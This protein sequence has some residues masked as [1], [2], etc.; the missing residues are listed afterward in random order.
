MRAS[1]TYFCLEGDGAEERG[2]S[3]EIPPNLELDIVNRVSASVHSALVHNR[4]Y[5]S[6]L[7]SLHVVLDASCSI[8]PVLGVYGTDE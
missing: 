7:M 2:G 8:V 5:D 3:G 4:Y 1:G 6:E